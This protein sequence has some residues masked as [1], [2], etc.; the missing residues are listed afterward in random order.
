[1]NSNNFILSVCNQNIKNINNISDSDETNSYHSFDT[2]S[3]SDEENNTHNFN[4][5]TYKNQ[6]E[7]LQNLLNN[8][9]EKS[10]N[11]YIYKKIIISLKRVNEKFSFPKYYCT[12]N[13]GRKKR[14]NKNKKINIYKNIY[15]KRNNNTYN[16]NTNNNNIYI[17][18]YSNCSKIKFPRL[19]SS[20]AFL[21]SYTYNKKQ[22]EKLTKFWTVRY[23]K[24]ISERIKY[25]ILFNNPHIC[26]RQ[27]KSKRKIYNF[28]WILKKKKKK[29]SYLGTNWS[30][31]HNK[32]KKKNLSTRK[33][34][35]R[36]SLNFVNYDMKS[37]TIENCADEQHCNME[38]EEE[39]EHMKG[40]YNIKH[41]KQNDNKLSAN[42]NDNEKFYPYDNIN[43]EEI[44]HPNNFYSN[45]ENYEEK[46]KKTN[47]HFIGQNEDKVQEKIHTPFSGDHYNQ[48][49]EE[50]I[51]KSNPISNN[52][53]YTYNINNSF[54]MYKNIDNNYDDNINDTQ[55]NKTYMKNY[56][57]QYNNIIEYMKYPCNYNACFPN[58]MTNNIPSQ[59]LY[60]ENLTTQHSN[61]KKV[62]KKKQQLN[63]CCT[64]N[65]PSNSNSTLFYSN[66]S[67]IF[68]RPSNIYLDPMMDS[69]YLYWN[70]RDWVTPKNNNNYNNNYNNNNNEN[71]N[72]EFMKTSKMETHITVNTNNI[73]G[74]YNNSSS[75]YN[76]NEVNYQVDEN[77]NNNIH[78]INDHKKSLHYNNFVLPY[79]YESYTQDVS[80]TY[81][82]FLQ[83]ANMQYDQKENISYNIFKNDNKNICE[84][85][86]MYKNISPSKEDHYHNNNNNNN[87]END[88][89][90][91]SNKVT[92]YIK[93]KYDNKYSYTKQ[94][95][96]VPFKSLKNNLEEPKYLS[97]GNLEQEKNSF[98]KEKNS[99][100][101]EKNSFEKEKNVFF[102]SIKNVLC[103]K[104]EIKKIKINLN[105]QRKYTFL[106]MDEK[107]KNELDNL[108]GYL[109]YQKM[110]RKKLKEYYFNKI[111]KAFFT[112]LL[113]SNQANFSFSPQEVML[114]K[115]WNLLKFKQARKNHILRNIKRNT[116]MNYS[117]DH[118]KVIT[119]SIQG[120][121][122][123]EKNVDNISIPM[124]VTNNNIVFKP[125]NEYM[126]K[127]YYLNNLKK[128]QQGD[129]IIS[130]ADTNINTLDDKR[131][132]NNSNNYYKDDDNIYVDDSLSNDNKHS[133]FKS[134]NILSYLSTHRMIYMKNKKNNNSNNNSNN[135]NN[136][137][138]NNLICNSFYN[139]KLLPMPSESFYELYDHNKT[140]I[141]DVFLF[142]K[143]IRYKN[144][145]KSF[146]KKLKKKKY[147]Y[148]S[149]I[150]NCNKMLGHIK[151]LFVKLL[152]KE[153][154]DIIGIYINDCFINS[155]ICFFLSL[156]LFIFKNI[157]TIKIIRSHIYLSYFNI[158]L[159]YF[160][161]NNLKCMYFICNN[162]LYDLMVE[163]DT[164]SIHDNNE[165]S[166]SKNDELVI[167]HNIYNENIYDNDYQN[168]R[169]KNFLIYF[170]Q[171][172]IKKKKKKK[173]KIDN[174]NKSDQD[175]KHL[176]EQSEENTEKKK[177]YMEEK[178][179]LYINN[180]E[181]TK[182]KQIHKKKKK[183]Y[184]IIINKDK[185][186]KNFMSTC[187]ENKI[188][189][190]KK[191]QII[192]FDDDGFYNYFTKKNKKNKKN[193]HT[194]KEYIDGDNKENI[195]GNNKENIS[196]NNKENISGNN[197]EN[198]DENKQ[199]NNNNNNNDNND[200]DG[201]IKTSTHDTN[202]KE[203]EQMNMKKKKN[204]NNNKMDRK[205]SKLQQFINKLKM[206][207]GND[208]TTKMDNNNDESDDNDDNND[209]NDN[210][211]DNNN[212]DDHNDH[213]NNNNDNH[214]NNN[215]NH[216][217][218]INNDNGSDKHI[219]KYNIHSSSNDESCMSLDTLDG[220]SYDNYSHKIPKKHL[221]YLDL[222]K[223][224]ILKLCSNKLDDDALI[225]ISNL[226]KK[227][228]LNNLKV[229][230]L[231]WNNFTY[232]SLLTLSFSLTNIMK[233]NEST[234][235]H[236]R[237][238]QTDQ[239]KKKIQKIQLNKLLL[240]G[241][242]INSSLYSSF[243][244]SF[245]TCNYIVV[246]NLDF[247]MN[248]IDNE[249]F[250][251]TYKYLQHIK[252]IQEKKKKALF[253][254]KQ[255]YKQHKKGTHNK[256][257]IVQIKNESMNNK[258][259]K[260]KGGNI[261]INLDHNNLKNS[262]YI[263]KIK[264]LLKNFPIQN[265]KKKKFI[266]HINYNN[267]HVI[268]SMQ[269]NNINNVY[270]NQEN[271]KQKHKI[272][273]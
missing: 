88:Y 247:S 141:F 209:N 89:N 182:E 74:I 10:N 83:H 129:N 244:S 104:K 273:I 133:L 57:H 184:K 63:P 47:N 270:T 189:Y 186:K 116:H 252:K 131:G 212:K 153:I 19:S 250:P 243:L 223:L 217:N 56:D 43:Q 139:N 144:V 264:K 202:Y 249:S 180:S 52:E 82:K 254:R 151:Y 259:I 1:M 8:F 197:K 61:K 166:E 162:I 51:N 18:S 6:I 128:H 130:Y 215:D 26:E 55:N 185:C 167:N 59:D 152:R 156:I 71:Y 29:N 201:V 50:N 123:V 134:N 210:N 66:Q 145:E 203:N 119:S 220:D 160:K 38:E 86:K 11:F 164:L 94:L 17:H 107:K 32:K 9:I 187:E 54:S 225:Y 241:N 90:H 22:I 235:N 234:N 148:L 227:K 108:I 127:K 268:L 177:K 150:N 100:E 266:N 98:E 219:N 105:N 75:F 106:N 181:Q 39:I 191:K 172:Y 15:N 236:I 31:V 21:A 239:R 265:Y 257:K 115:K 253:K 142:L 96:S 41:V 208:N 205:E 85:N 48:E 42:Q 111:N 80:S 72:T 179:N 221:Y 258:N 267:Q 5:R 103:L 263:N 73:N 7:Y 155:T 137:N 49:L 195:S 171:N 62:K 230:D 261:Y 124:P 163:M 14:K 27:N 206:K 168:K 125:L 178:N 262:V 213:H 192:F 53:I 110:I 194:N 211:D 97:T 199:T 60:E 25:E 45:N 28:V 67:K 198:I 121:N 77:K 99:F 255:M 196:G 2:F 93:N 246:K 58:I 44:F 76:N 256:T 78:N 214:N 154:T 46:I 165:T 237:K 132:K 226:I 222:N 218:N 12:T 233:K 69:S 260:N 204:N 170:N 33:I 169:Y 207:K 193:E 173:K 120:K 30:C 200:D 157:H 35:K 20:S 149:N 16:N 81:N 3:K 146:K 113:R 65:I 4:N 64:F 126:R 232:K 251:I 138:N 216:N 109:M 136:N 147:I 95:P 240:S 92:P 228:K 174:N 36:I 112:F 37:T 140:N 122:H 231:R 175:E 24:S 118:E 143:N 91:D 23:I 238:E 248:K 188:V 101:K 161:N 229:L 13:L 79:P 34:K 245:C 159:D 242:N 272:Q 68:Y 224:E 40:E 183:K 190:K 117:D 176:V 269:Y 70:E 102:H 271:I 87:N 84:K 114:L 158:F 135:N